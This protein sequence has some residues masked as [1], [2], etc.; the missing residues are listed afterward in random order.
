MMEARTR[1]VAVAVAVAEAVA[2]ASRAALAWSEALVLSG[3]AL[4]LTAP[5]P[6]HSQHSALPTS[7]PASLWRVL[8]LWR[9]RGVVIITCLWWHRGDRRVLVCSP[10]C[11]CRQPCLDKTTSTQT[12]KEEDKEDKEEEKEKEDKEEDKGKE[13]ERGTPV[14]TSFLTLILIRARWCR[15]GARGA[16]IAG[17]ARGVVWKGRGRRV[18]RGRGSVV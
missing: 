1:A 10:R 6:E 11:C 4:G 9:W 8:W 12:D 17:R 15:L 18:R 7:R 3:C 14:P 13:K 16:C 2:E 5:R